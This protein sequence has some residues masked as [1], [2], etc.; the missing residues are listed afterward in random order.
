MAFAHRCARCL[1]FAFAFGIIS[2]AAVRHLQS[3]AGP[4]AWKNDLTPIGA[5]DWS[6]ERAAHLL[7]RAGFG[8]TP[9]EIERLVKLGPARAVDFLVDYEKTPNA[10]P[11][12]EESG[13]YDAGMLPD[14]DYHYADFTEGLRAG[15]TKGIV[16]GVKPNPDGIRRYQPVID[17]LYYRGFSSAAE[18]RR[19]AQWWAGRMLATEHPLEEKMT[20]YWHGHFATE[21]SKVDDYRL[22]LQQIEMLRAGATGNFRNLLLGIARDPAMLIY[23]DNRKNVQGKP[24]ENFA[25]EIMELFSLGAGNYTEHDI[26]EAA[27]AF[28]GW[29]N[30]GLQF[31][32]HEDL[33]DSGEKTVLGKTGNF[34]G[35][36]VVDILLEQKACA[37]FISRKLYRYLVREDVPPEL[38]M[39]LA[40]LVR[41]NHYEWKPFL[42]TVFLS[43]DFY[44]P[45]SFA[46]QIKSP[47]V[48]LVSTYKKMGLT[49]I[50]GTPYY[51]T[52]MANLGQNLGNPPNVKGWDGGRAWVNP[53]TLLQRCNVVRHVLSPEEAAAEYPRD[54]VPA[55]YA[56]AKKEAEERDRMIAGGQA[57]AP[58]AA[59]TSTDGGAACAQD[60]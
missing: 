48:Y 5:S 32:M 57:A 8:G 51:P 15:M 10:L 33:H 31:A 24:N 29:D 18:W 34:S 30:R 37:E 54:T 17:M 14:V 4:Q 42:R 12:F 11:R 28:T 38:Q 20:L 7:E 47:V 50:P 59:K 36:D 2:C 21:N 49:E 26:K 52:V 39:K 43:R 44:S 13:I 6:Y 41:A 46:T 45:A 22:M 58:V 40:A 60:Q 19:A 35:E 16:Y 3:G 27:R 55:R 9:E 53:S 56:N 25:R 23:L 1:S